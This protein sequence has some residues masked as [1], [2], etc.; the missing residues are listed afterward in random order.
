MDAGFLDKGGSMTLIKEPEA[1]AFAAIQRHTRETSDS[2]SPGDA[3]IG[4]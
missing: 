1:A 4:N 3:F 2:T